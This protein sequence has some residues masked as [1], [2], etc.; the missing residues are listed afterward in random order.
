MYSIIL[1]VFKELENLKI[2]IPEIKNL[3]KEI[4]YEIII[5]DDNSND[6]TS[7]YI[8]NNFPETIYFNR[9]LKEPSLG[10]SVG[11]GIK[12]SK[13]QFIMV[14]DSD[15]SHKTDY[16][17]EMIEYQKVNNY[18]LICCS[19]FF[20]IKP[21]DFSI[22]FYL[23]KIYCYFLKIFLNLQTNDG[24]SGFF[25]LEKKYLENTHFNE[26]FYGY[27]DFYFR[28]LFYL[29]KKKIK[30][31]NMGFKWQDRK[32]GKSKTKFINIFIKYSFEAVKLKF[33]NY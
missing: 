4:K 20:K 9:K 18:N 31:L 32:I 23:S 33:K 17:L 3:L 8:Q 13:Y 30:Y 7:E 19:R 27:G 16:L 21:K 15:F 2:L 11:D 14:M 5:I 12:I 29:K 1:P 6:G 22:R 25:L 10:A 28:L 26:I 24:L